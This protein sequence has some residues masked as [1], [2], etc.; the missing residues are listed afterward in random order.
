MVL[1]FQ[2]MDEMLRVVINYWM[3]ATEHYFPLVLFINL[4]KLDLTLEP[5][6]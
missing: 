4:Y 3:K 1:T 2:L 5:K 6:D